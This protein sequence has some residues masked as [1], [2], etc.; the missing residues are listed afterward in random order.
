VGRVRPS[1]PRH[2]LPLHRRVLADPAALRR[3]LLVIALALAAA[4]IT[5]RVVAAAEDARA[6]WGTTRSVLVTEA[7]VAAG[8]PVDAVVERRWPVALAPPDALGTL[9]T[10][11][12]AAGPLAPGVPLT[13]SAL[14]ARGTDLDRSRMALPAGANPLPLDPGDRVDVWT[15]VD[16]SLTGAA[17]TTRRVAADVT[18]VTADP[19]TVVV[20]VDHEEVAAVAEAVALATLTLVATS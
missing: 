20:A 15:T 10:D 3:W 1:V 8:E 5:W 14:A 2:R 11:A 17:P 4:S 9:P 13:A 19:D 18:V 6:A 12:R 16:P 7:P